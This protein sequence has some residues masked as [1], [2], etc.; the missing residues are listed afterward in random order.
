MASEP[1]VKCTQQADGRGRVR[2]QGGILSVSAEHQVPIRVLV[3]NRSEI[4]SELLAD[5]IA[6]D[7]RFVAVGWSV[8]PAVI[9]LL[10][11]DTHPDVLLITPKLDDNPSAGL[12]V[13]TEFRICHPGL[14]VVV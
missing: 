13:L 4:E 10:A 7:R 12:E 2:S 6:K 11:G 1:F 8:Q 5:A 9:D 14:K 3:A